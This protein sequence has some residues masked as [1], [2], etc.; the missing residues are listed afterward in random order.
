MTDRQNAKLNM[1]QKVLDVCNEYKEEYAGIPV[2][3]TAVNVLKTR[4]SEIQSVTQ[5][6][7]GTVSKGATKDK[8]DVFDRLVE[9]AL[10]VAN[11]IYVYAFDT[12]NN[13]LLQKINVNKSMFYRNHDREALTLAKIILDEANAYSTTL[14]DYGV[15]NIDLAELETAISQFESLITAPSGVIGE[16]KLHTSNLRE[17]FVAAD[18]TVYDKLD[19]LIRL[20]KSSKPEFFTLYSNARNIVNTAARKRKNKEKAATEE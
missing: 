8:N 18:S 15:N 7:T 6:Q 19:K 4:V 14:T 10:K 20:F 9:L 17:L 12:S 13:S 11:P 16:H 5:Q 3:V 2:L 1:Y